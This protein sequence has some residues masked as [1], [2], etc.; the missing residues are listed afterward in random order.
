LSKIVTDN[1]I[2]GQQGAN[3]IENII[4]NA[5]WIWRPTQIFDTGLDGE[6]ELRNP[7]TGTMTGYIIK[8]QSKSGDSYFKAETENNFEYIAS[9]KDLDYWLNS[10]L[11][12]LLIISRPATNEAYWVSIKEYFQKR[13]EDRIAKKILFDK[14]N[15]IFDTTITYKLFECPFLR[16]KGFYRPPQNVDEVLYSNLIP[17]T[18]YPPTIYFAPTR[19]RTK[20]SAWKKL[21]KQGE[22]IGIEWFLKDKK[23]YSFIDVAKSPL[24]CLLTKKGET[25]AIHSKDWAYSNDETERKD[26]VRLLNL[27]LK[28]KFDTIRFRY[29]KSLNRYYF[30]P[31]RNQIQTRLP[32]KVPYKSFQRDS[33][34]T[35]FQAYGHKTKFNILYYYRHLAFET[36]F[37]EFGEKYYLIITPT[38][39]F[40]NRNLKFS[41]SQDEFLRKI[42]QE[43]NNA[44]LVRYVR[45]IAQLLSKTRDGDLFPNYEMIKF[46]EEEKFNINVGLT[47]KL[48]LNNDPRHLNELVDEVEDQQQDFVFVKL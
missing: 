17:V 8:V 45:C 13:P 1:N 18:Y 39:V 32:I 26:F 10:N 36:N 2:L 29:N 30:W 20:K 11:P 28:A 48:W 3:L 19:V 7:G 44:N 9:E 27:C 43:E 41:K 14:K 6:I 5:G 40:K 25:G 31:E 15:N 38:Y 47:D 35:V 12:V 4:L 16:D 23:I 34:C 24:K 42:K 22:P 37:R 46:C 33:H 21:N